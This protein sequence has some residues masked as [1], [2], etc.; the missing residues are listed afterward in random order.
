MVERRNGGK[1]HAAKKL[2]GEASAA[3]ELVKAL[4]TVNNRAA[5]RQRN[6]QCV[7]FFDPKI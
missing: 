1:K 6:L 2:G 7:F 4:A 5:Y 3:T